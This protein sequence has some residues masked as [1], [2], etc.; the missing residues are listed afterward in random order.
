[1]KLCDVCIW[2]NFKRHKSFW[3]GINGTSIKD[4]PHSDQSFGVKDE[5]HSDQS[6]GRK[7]HNKA[8]TAMNGGLMKG[9]VR[10]VEM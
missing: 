4:E 7:W 9:T 1:M 3:G 2:A 5:P 6:F 10:F 8:E